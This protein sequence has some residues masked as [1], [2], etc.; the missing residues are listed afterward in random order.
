MLFVCEVA[1]VNMQPAWG[2]LDWRYRY[3][4]LMVDSLSR[5]RTL[6][7]VEQSLGTLG[8]PADML[9]IVDVQ[10]ETFGAEST[11]LVMELWVR[12]TCPD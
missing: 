9:G 8:V 2:L 11:A 4:Y 1:Q 5:H 6:V 3:S 7:K 10:R 12:V